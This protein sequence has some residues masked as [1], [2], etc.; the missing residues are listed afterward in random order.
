[1]AVED[2]LTG[3]LRDALDWERSLH[4]V[5]NIEIAETTKDVENCHRYLQVTF[6]EE[7][8]LYRQANNINFL[9]LR[10]YYFI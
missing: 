8:Y 5:S 1:M 6:A 3:F 9:E 4:S 2:R 7:F 10:D